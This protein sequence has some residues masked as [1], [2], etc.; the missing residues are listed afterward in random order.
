MTTDT[1]AKQ[2]VVDGAGLVGR[3]HGQGRRHARPGSWPR[4]SSSSPPTPSPRQTTSTPRCAPRPG[5]A[6]TGSTP[7]AACPPTTPS[8]L[9]ASGASGI[10]PTAARPH[11]RPDAGLHRPRPAA[12]RGRR[13]RRPRHRDHACCTP[14]P[15]TTRSR[16]PASV[17]RSNLFKAA[18]FGND[19]NWG[20]V[21]AQH[22]HDAGGVRPRRPRRRDQRRLGLPAVDAGGR[23]G[24]G[25]PERPARSRSRRPQGR[26]TPGRRSGPTT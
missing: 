17:A 14:P 18:V 24:H 16:S 12:A 1:V 2:A 10:T 9:L 8:P 13:G 6:S 3:R 4:C 23:P 21:L 19:P 22:R 7:T 26:A 15:R 5:S 25:R 20:R 11:R